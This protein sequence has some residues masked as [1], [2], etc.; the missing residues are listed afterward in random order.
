MFPR[1][2]VYLVSLHH[3]V[4]LPVLGGDRPP[5]RTEL[6]GVAMK[7]LWQL[8]SPSLFPSPPV[9]CSGHD[10]CIVQLHC[11]CISCFLCYPADTKLQ[12]FGAMSDIW[13]EVI[14]P[15]PSPSPLHDH[16]FI[17]YVSLVDAADTDLD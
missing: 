14:L 2:S 7:S 10:H 15:P 13:P 8:I 17:V 12:S 16:P 4:V 6:H 5:R 11:V 3:V 9:T 1:S